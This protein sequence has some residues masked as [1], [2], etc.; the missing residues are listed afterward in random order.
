MTPPDDFPMRPGG[1]TPDCEATWK[2]IPGDR[3]DGPSYR[4]ICG[5]R[6]CPSSLGV[7]RSFDPRWAFPL[8]TAIR[9]AETLRA[10]I[11]EISEQLSRIKTTGG[12]PADADKARWI[13]L[14]DRSIDLTGRWLALH[15]EAQD[16]GQAENDI[17]GP[18]APQPS[19]IMMLETPPVEPGTSRIL[20]PRPIYCGFPDTGYRISQRGKRAGNG[21]RI[22]RRPFR[23]GDDGRDPWIAPGQVPIPPCR[24]YCPV[25]G[26]LNELPVP[27]GFTV[28]ER[29]G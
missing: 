28:V 17:D 15:R 13:S 26:T 14:H 8:G 20:R 9:E 11:Q 21:Q 10:E 1:V 24:I 25:C 6:G 4:A 29:D 18:T 19:W 27:P 12:V 5:K 2:E 22:S 3:D 23:G 16:K 7:L